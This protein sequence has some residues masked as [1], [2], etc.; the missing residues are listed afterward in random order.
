MTRKLMVFTAAVAA[1]SVVTTTGC[2]NSK[3]QLEAT[4]AQVQTIS[5][6]KD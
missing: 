1:F 3:K 4:L 6:E 5:A 2:D